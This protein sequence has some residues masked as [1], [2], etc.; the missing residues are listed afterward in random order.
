[1]AN[2][3]VQA[4]ENLFETKAK[5]SITVMHLRIFINVQKFALHMIC[6]TFSI[7]SYNQKRENPT[8]LLRHWLFM[9]LDFSNF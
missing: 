6:V 4:K 9:D 2:F 1:M 7:L 5:T 3:D 8:V